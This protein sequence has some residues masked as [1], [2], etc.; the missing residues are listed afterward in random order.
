M[1]ADEILDVQARHW[2]DT[3]VRHGANYRGVD[4]GNA[5]RVQLCFRQLTAIWKDR[6]S[7]SVLDFGCGYGALLGYLR[8]HG[9]ALSDY[10][11]FDV[12]EEMIAHARQVNATVPGAVFTGDAGALQ[13]ADY[14][15]CAGIFNVKLNTDV[16]AWHEHVVRTLD[17]VWSLC[18]RGMAFNILTS[19]SEPDKMRPDLYYAD[20]CWFFDHCKRNLSRDVALIHDYGVYEFTMLVQK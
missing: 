8:N 5:E 7:A 17:Q 15:I 6:G 19:Y 20:P 2:S 16:A 1:N 4:Y 14:V 12:S 3:I 18:R 9:F 11:G 13:P 10:T